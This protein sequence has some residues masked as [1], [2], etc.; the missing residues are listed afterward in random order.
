MLDRLAPLLKRKS[1][2]ILCALLRVIQPALYLVRT[3]TMNFGLFT[4]L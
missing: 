2:K 3:G 4:F 1:C